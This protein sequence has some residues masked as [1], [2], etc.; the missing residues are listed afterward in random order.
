MYY[1]FRKKV[2]V[3]ITTVIIVLAGALSVYLLLSPPVMDKSVLL[4]DQGSAMPKNGVDVSQ[5]SN[6]NQNETELVESPAHTGTPLPSELPELTEEYPAVLAIPPNTQPIETQPD[7]VSESADESSVIQP[8]T[9]PNEVLPDPIITE[10]PGIPG[11]PETAEYLKIPE[12]PAIPHVL[13]Q[14]YEKAPGGA[15]YF[16]LPEITSQLVVIDDTNGVIKA[17]FFTKDVE[18]NWSEIPELNTRAWGGSNGVRPKLREGDKVTPVGQFPIWEAFYIN[19]EPDTNLDI[20]KITKDTYWVDDPGSVYY[21]KRVEGTQD[22]DWT[23]AE[24]MITYP[25]SYK[26]GFVIGYNP[27]CIPRLGSA[28]FFHVAQRN[29]AGCIGVSEEDCL[30][31]L[32]ILDKSQSPYILIVSTNGA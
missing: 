3:L 21:N 29:T 9:I 16:D 30:K 14:Y 31:Y 23:S 20:F 22:K 15:S 4:V 6:S 19:K 12:Y 13:A 7:Y 25:D 28:V 17:L 5:A 1:R 24:H 2:L 32:A 10:I 8:T 11:I 26:Y 18:G 27:D